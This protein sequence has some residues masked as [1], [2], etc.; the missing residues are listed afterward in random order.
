[1]AMAEAQVWALLA[2]GYI[3]ADETL[4]YRFIDL[5]G[6]TPDQ[7]RAA[8]DH[9]QTLAATAQFLLNNEE[10]L[11]GFCRSQGLEPAGVARAFVD[12]SHSGGLASA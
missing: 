11:L 12:L 9:P 8:A 10:D 2:L 4:I 7:L 1:M 5:T 3:A 6:F